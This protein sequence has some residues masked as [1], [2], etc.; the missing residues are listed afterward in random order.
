[1]NIIDT[2]TKKQ[3]RTDLP[4][5]QVG[6]TVTVGIKVKEGSKERIQEFKGLVMSITGSGVGKS[7]TVRKVSQGIGVE[8]ILPLNSPSIGYL[9]VDRKG[10][11]HQA[12]LGYV[13]K[14]TKQIKIK[15]RN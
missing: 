13:R 5:F 9:N 4:T 7:F 1:M 6:D 10:S 11:V 2:I 14:A 8:R 12:K 3:I 15:E